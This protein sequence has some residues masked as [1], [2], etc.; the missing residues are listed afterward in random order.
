MSEIVDP[1]ASDRRR[2]WGLLFLAG[3]GIAM[4]ALAGWLAWSFVYAPWPAATAD[5]R[6]E[7]LG[8]ALIGSLGLTGIVLTG[9]AGL[10]VKRTL[11]LS[12]DGLEVTDQ[13]GNGS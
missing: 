5:E 3:G 8:W 9:F 12:K 2:N 4:T 10:I 1:V 7:W 6:I 11:R 13:A